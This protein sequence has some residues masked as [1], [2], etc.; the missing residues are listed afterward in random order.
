M[1]NI[2]EDNVT[3]QS[4]AG[5]AYL[6]P[7]TTLKQHL[8][9]RIYNQAHKMALLVP[10]RNC[11][12]ELNQFAPYIETF[13]N[14]QKIAHT[15]Y[16]INQTDA[17]SFNRATLINVGF[18]ESDPNCDYIAMHDV[19]LLPLNPL[20]NYSFP[21]EG[22][23]HVS[24]PKLHPKYHYPSFIGG[25]LLI[26]RKHFESVNGMSNLF[27]GWGGED[28]EFGLR[29]LHFGMKVRHPVDVKTGVR[30]TFRHIHNSKKR[31]R[32]QYRYHKQGF[33]VYTLTEGGRLN[34]TVDSTVQIMYR[35][36][37]SGKI[38][39]M[40]TYRDEGFNSTEDVYRDGGLNSTEAVY[41]DGGLNSTER[42][43]S[44]G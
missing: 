5:N 4:Q 43:Y 39:Q 22:P 27:W 24:S 42:I 13:L 15:I 23:Y 31:P 17:Y 40:Y 20:L 35:V 14:N 11:S 44:E 2:D 19:D 41:S 25:I 30:D 33:E 36:K 37:E 28:D 9:N 8:G 12:E 29:L 10:F 6:L 26:T 18:L 7:G 16:V 32:D 21:S 38:P 3:V 34:R 1:T